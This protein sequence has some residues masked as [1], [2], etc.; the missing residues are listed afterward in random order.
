MPLDQTA[1]A[2]FATVI[3]VLLLAWVMTPSFL[4][5][6]AD[7]RVIRGIFGILF[8]IQVIGLIISLLGVATGGLPGEWGWWVLAG[9]AAG[10]IIIVG[11]FYARLLA[12]VAAKSLSDPA[13]DQ[14]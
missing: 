3:P 13:S 6:L 12:R 8:G 11:T 10:I 1:C 4:D 7:F 2:T 14:K 9:A 5:F